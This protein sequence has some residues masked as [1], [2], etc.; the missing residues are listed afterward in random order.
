[1]SQICRSAIKLAGGRHHSLRKYIFFGT[2]VSA[3]SRVAVHRRLST[4]KRLKQS[5]VAEEAIKIPQPESTPV[6]QKSY[7]P[8]ITA[9]VDQI[10]Q[11]NLLEV[12]DLNEL[13]KNRLNIR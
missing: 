8:K 10:S 4:A 1:M 7:A 9:I 13:L 11:L 2:E 5:A 12:A 3:C 6:E